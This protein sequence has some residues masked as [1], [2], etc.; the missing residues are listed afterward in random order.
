MIKSQQIILIRFNIRY[1]HFFIIIDF[2]FLL[3]EILLSLL[4]SSD[5]LN[6]GTT[7]GGCVQFNWADAVNGWVLVTR[8]DPLPESFSSTTAVLLLLLLTSALHARVEDITAV[9]LLSVWWL[10]LLSLVLLHVRSWLLV[11]LFHGL[12]L[13]PSVVSA[14]LLTGGLP[15]SIISTSLSLVLVLLSVALVALVLL[16]GVTVLLPALES[17]VG[18]GIIFRPA[19]NVELLFTA[20]IVRNFHWGLHVV[21]LLVPTLRLSVI[22]IPRLL[23]LIGVNVSTLRLI[24]A[25]ALAV[26][27]RLVI[28][29]FHGPKGL[30][31]VLA[32][33]LAGLALVVIILLHWWLAPIWLVHSIKARHLAFATIFGDIISAPPKT[34]IT[35]ST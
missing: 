32:R 14:L 2:Y 16:F 30:V 6:L 27:L 34:E 4:S 8:F 26:P 3:T 9:L 35:V 17:V 1:T 28:I 12:L 10:L 22:A 24:L 33:E 11:V 25:L 18:G 13:G 29:L 7:T 20:R 19:K 21:A 5:Q 15:E 23:H 31:R